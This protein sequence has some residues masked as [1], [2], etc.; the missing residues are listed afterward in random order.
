MPWFVFT[1][2]K[3]RFRISG[4]GRVLVLDIFTFLVNLEVNVRHTCERDMR[5]IRVYYTLRSSRYALW[6][7]SR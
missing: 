2:K 6:L 7:K 1:A 5:D 3:W 4:F